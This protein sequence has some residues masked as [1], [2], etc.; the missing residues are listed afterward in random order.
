MKVKILK[1]DPEVTLPEYKTVESAAFDLAANE[2]AVIKPREIKLIRTGLVMEAPV[3][4]FLMI[5]PRSSLPRKKGLSIPQSVGIVDR[6]YSGPEDEILLQVYN[7]TD[8]D[9]SVT[10]GER[11]AQGIFLKADRVEWEEVK[12]IRAQSRGGFGSTGMK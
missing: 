11:L 8:Q 12:Q 4:H 6:D 3:G 9:V 10:K 1:L 5:A 2:D 7:F